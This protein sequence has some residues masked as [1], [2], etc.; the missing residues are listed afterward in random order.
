MRDLIR[1]VEQDGNKSGSKVFDELDGGNIMSNIRV[2]AWL[3][4]LTATAWLTRYTEPTRA[5]AR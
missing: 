2:V 5:R 1:S 3:A 4:W